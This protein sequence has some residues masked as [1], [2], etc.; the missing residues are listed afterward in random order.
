MRLGLYLKIVEDYGMNK[1]IA[2][3]LTAVCM[4]LSGGAKAAD[5]VADKPVAK[6]EDKPAESGKP[7]GNSSDVSGV[8][9]PKPTTPITITKLPD[10][11]PKNPPIMPV[12]VPAWK[13]IEPPADV[14]PAGMVLMNKGDG[15]DGLVIKSVSVCD[16]NNVWCVANDGKADA[17]YQLTSKGLEHRFDG[18]FVAAGKEIVSAINQQNEVFELV[19]GVGDEWKKVDGLKLT[20]ISRP[21]PNIGWGVFDDG[22]GVTTFFSYDE[23][24]KKWNVVKNA[25]GVNAKGVVDCSAN[26]EEV[27]L[28]LNEKGELLK[29]DLQRMELNEKVKEAIKRGSKKDG[30]KVD[31][32][33]GKKLANQ[34][35]GRRQPNKKDMGKKGADKSE[36]R[37]EPKKK[38]MNK[39]VKEEIEK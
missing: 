14:K 26:A 17:V 23:H 10:V 2:I 9:T 20:K 28:I 22:K 15:H 5:K 30:G 37:S 27:V 25:L 21:S 19:G 12:S 18:V 24:A 39:K 36:G 33:H 34:S 16:Q 32:K 4:W 31:R 6:V 29:S 1:K 13:P 38:E 7:V 11:D 3:V 8:T 35:G